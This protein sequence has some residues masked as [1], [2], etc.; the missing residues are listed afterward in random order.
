MA[1]GLRDFLSAVHTT[2]NGFAKLDGALIPVANRD[3]RLTVYSS[4]VEYDRRWLQINLTS[5]EETL[6]LLLNVSLET[7][8]E[9]T[10][11]AI[12]RWLS[13]PPHHQSRVIEIG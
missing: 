3:W 11:D 4:H 9:T 5:G 1:S 13:A 10:V 7:K 8:P 12:K 2:L 6:G